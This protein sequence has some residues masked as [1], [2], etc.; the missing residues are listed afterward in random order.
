M[1]VTDPH[2]A[3]QGVLVEEPGSGKQMNAPF[4]SFTVMPMPLPVERPMSWTS[5]Q[6]S[7]RT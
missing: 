2:Q 6:S 1:L 3:W 4:F 5:F 7:E